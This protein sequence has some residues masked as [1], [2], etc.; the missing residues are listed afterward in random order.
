MISRFGPRRT[1]ATSL[2]LVVALGSL[3][4]VALAQGPLDRE[5]SF[6]R[7]LA[8]D[9]KFIELAKSEADRLAIEFRNA[10]DQDKIAQLAVEITYY[11]ARSR[12]DRAQQRALFKETLDKSKE[13]IERSSDPLVQV[14]ARATLANASQDFGQFLVQELEIARSEAPEKA[15]ELEEEAAG[16]FRAG[17][18]ACGKVM[19]VLKGQRK[20]PQKEVEYGLMWMK[21]AVLSRE[22]G[23]ADKANREA[24]IERAVVELTELVLEFGEE[25]AIGL[26]GLFEIAQ[27]KEVGGNVPEAIDS[28]RGTVSS[29]VTSLKQAKE[30]EINLSG[31]MQSFLFTML[32]EVYVRTGE[33][34]VR[35]GSPETGALF[36]EFRTNMAEF[37][38]KGIDL[39]DVVSEEHGHLMLLAESKFLA[40]SGDAKKVADAMA[41][42]QRINDKHPS[43]YVGVRAKAT[44]RDI[45]SVQQN[46]VSGALLVEIA[47]GEHQNKNYEAAIKGLRKALV[48]MTADDQAKLGLE[49]YRLLGLSYAFTDRYLEAILAL[50][51]GLQRFG[52]ND[53][54]RASDLADALDRAITQLKRQTKND[55]AFDPTYSAAAT[56][57][58]KFGAG[59]GAKL[60]WKQG[61]DLMQQKKYA[62][63]I[64]QYQLIPADFL[65]Y[66]AARV[67]VARAHSASGDFAAARTALGE[68]RTWAAANEIPARDT[69]KQQ[70]RANALAVAE[71][72]EVQMAYFEARGNEE[73]KLKKDLTKYPAAIEKAQGY[74]TNFQKDGEG[75]IPSALEFLGRLHSDLAALDRA[76][77]AYTQLKQ[78]DTVRASRLATDIFKEYQEQVKALKG[79]LDQTIAKDKGDAAILKAT[80]DLKAVRQKLVALGMD[81]IAGSPKPQL[82]ILVGTMINWEELRDW[83]RVD[84][85]AQ[86]T[87]ALY[88]EDPAEATKKTLDL[89]VRPKVGE[90][91]LQQQRFTEAYAMLSAAETANPTQW[92]LKRQLARTLGGWYEM[93]DRGRGVAVLGLDKPV[94]AYKKYYSEYRT[95]GLRPEVKQFS[96]DWYRFHWE[97]YWFAKQAG[98]KDTKFKDIADKLYRI[99]R[100][101]DDFATLK[102]YGAEGLQLFNFFRANRQ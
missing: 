91:L 27:A 75:N 99:A 21:K 44:L 53:K 56:E 16:V 36:T 48:V 84:E 65:Q 47:K 63:A 98:A 28:Y 2:W 50:T 7:A 94:D 39:F 43:D 42:T 80:N 33:V 71:F 30:G 93:D 97:T 101:T 19:E 77:E 41:M 12:T 86:K 15:K 17:I 78:R 26:R 61:N 73:L 54:D 85:V 96:L 100:A 88:G 3:S 24:L 55:A 37:G 82:G 76:E 68:F 49:S 60:F 69:G 40:E 9:M 46:L 83:A 67:N 11:G 95:W 32:Q 57:I 10:A 31:E 81:Y 8:R 18:E 62:D 102:T 5:V 34:M 92:E 23:R 35:E 72:L 87:L 52:N 45:L 74:V 6:V 64:A 79:E 13:L 90:A 14:E 22:Q 51:T 89:L 25:T 20:D 4:P 38:E 29:I 70:V 59:A 58:A 1:G 66:E